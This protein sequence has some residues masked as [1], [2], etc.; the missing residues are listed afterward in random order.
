LIAHTHMVVL[1]RFILSIRPERF[2]LLVGSLFG[3]LFMLFTPPFQVPD[4]PNHFFRSYQ[5]S[6]GQ[7]MS[8]KQDNRVGGVLPVSLEQITN[9]FMAICW[10]PTMRSD[11]KTIMETMKIPLNAKEQAF[12]DFPNT[13]MYSPF[14]YLPQAVGIFVFRIFHASPLGLFYA[15][16]LFS[17]LFWLVLVYYAIKIIPIHKWLM[18]LIALLPMSVY[19]SMAI[20]ADVPTN[21]ISFLCL[22]FILRLAYSD[23]PLTQKS[24]IQLCLLCFLQVS[25][26]LVYTPILLTVLFIPKQK[27]KSNKDYLL[28]AAILAVVIIITAMFWSSSMKSLY[29]P[30]DAYNPEFREGKPVIKDADMYRQMDYIKSHGTY[31]LDVFYKSIKG[32]YDMY[33]HG[34]IGTFG[35]LDTP[36]PGWLMYSMY[37]LILV[38]VIIDGGHAP[39]KWWHR[40][41]LLLGFVMA[42]AGMLLS[43]HLTWD[44]VG[45]E[46]I[47][48]IQGRYLVPFMPL[49][50]FAFYNRLSAKNIAM[51]LV[52]AGSFF[53]L[54]YSLMMIYARYFGA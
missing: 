12:M 11:R 53:S 34:Y 6:E 18:T 31:I 52:M 49:L 44:I 32:A 7:L 4:E 2:F 15:A 50:Y 8:V 51:I 35:W 28:K 42:A 23:E 14:C 19:V 30:Y 48:T 22:A 13:A 36:L 20:S 1:S 17:L 39:M 41:L 37:L 43:Q 3:I 5:L 40:C 27:F 16:R 47:Y 29:T 9:P 54:S 45:G 26:K 38:I 10:T 25:V 33:A 46:S 24:F 21:A